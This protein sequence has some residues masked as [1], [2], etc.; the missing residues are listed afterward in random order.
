MRN[1]SLS[2]SSILFSVCLFTAADAAGTAS[3]ETAAALNLFLSDRLETFT[4]LEE[5]GT[6]AADLSR[7]FYWPD[8]LL[9]GEGAGKAARGFDEVAAMIKA[10]GTE[11][12]SCHHA[13]FDPIVYS[14]RLAS[15]IFEYTCKT[16]DGKPAT[17]FSTI[18]VWEKRGKEWKIIREMFVSGGLR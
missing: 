5:R 9:T 1:I 17:K 4:E 15:Q 14:G 16:A 13:Q 2:L 10:A 11:L 18:Y 7:Q 12:G 8:A 3:G 6:P